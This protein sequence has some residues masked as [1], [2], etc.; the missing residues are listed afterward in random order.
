MIYLHTVY[1]APSL[2][3]RRDYCVP[4]V[5]P[6]GTDPKLVVRKMHALQ[7][8][9]MKEAV[10]LPTLFAVPE[11]LNAVIREVLER[12]DEVQGSYESRYE[13]RIIRRMGSQE[14][15]EIRPNRL[16]AGGVVHY[17]GES[18]D[19][20]AA[21]FWLGPE[22]SKHALDQGEWVRY[23]FGDKVSYSRLKEAMKHA[24]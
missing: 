4:F 3:I 13:S 18:K 7:D 24:G 14:I 8:R 22:H 11:L 10:S 5:D 15:V 9:L 20:V 21:L 19:G 1:F 6:K 2:G 23:L 17:Y 12:D 16:F